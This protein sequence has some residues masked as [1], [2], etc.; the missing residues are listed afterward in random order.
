[1]KSG[2][3]NFLQTSGP[4]QAYSGTTL[5]LYSSI[6]LYIG[7]VANW[8]YGDTKDLNVLASFEHL[9]RT[10]RTVLWGLGES[11][12]LWVERKCQHLYSCRSESLRKSFEGIP[13]QY[14]RTT[15]S[16]AKRHDAPREDK[17]YLLNTAQLNSTL[18]FFQLNYVRALC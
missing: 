6:S 9:C 15:H 18:V 17:K 13:W 4:L 7:P 5:P 16:D 1:M 3:L 11:L 2:N 8:K 12:Y 14:A 10:H